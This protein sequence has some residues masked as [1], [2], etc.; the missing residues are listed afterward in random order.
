MA[1][2]AIVHDECYGPEDPT[3][4]RSSGKRDKDAENKDQ[5]GQDEQF[6]DHRETTGPTKQIT[7]R[8]RILSRDHAGRRIN[9]AGI[10][11]SLSIYIIGRC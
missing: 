10:I 5:E 1:D 3:V 4:L 8:F 9:A 7:R 6:R 11:L 2:P